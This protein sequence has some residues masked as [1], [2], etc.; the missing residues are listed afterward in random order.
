MSPMHKPAR[1][2][3]KTSVKIRPINLSGDIR[4]IY[5]V[6]INSIQKQQNKN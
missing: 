2:K 6:Y 3:K 4:V 1:G 5:L